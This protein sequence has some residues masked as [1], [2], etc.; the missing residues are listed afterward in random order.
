MLDSDDGKEFCDELACWPSSERGQ[1]IVC[2]GVIAVI[3]VVTFCGLA[4]AYA[5]VTPVSAGVKSA[6]IVLLAAAGN[7][8]SS[9][10]G[11]SL[12]VAVRNPNFA[13]TAL[14]AAPLDADLRVAGRRFGGGGNNNGSGGGGVVR[15]ADAGNELKHKETAE[16]RVDMA[17][18][19]HAEEF[20]GGV[21]DV[22]VAL[23]GEVKYLPF[24]GGRHALSAF[25]QLK[26]LMPLQ[27]GAAQAAPL[28]HPAGQVRRF[29]GGDVGSDFCSSVLIHR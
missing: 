2:V 22:E 14:Y 18:E 8:T 17:G 4:I 21:V 19:L 9:S 6:S 24:H 16:Y 29:V 23:A 25:C 15:L 5:T 20:G 12:T 26:L 1:C 27:P 10:Y 13:L 7:N 28:F 11:I 3:F